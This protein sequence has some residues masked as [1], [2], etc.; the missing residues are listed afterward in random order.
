MP[1]QKWFYIILSSL[2]FIGLS[3]WFCLNEQY[4]FLAIP[5]LLILG[6]LTI[7]SL[8]ATFWVALFFTPL[9]VGLLEFFPNLG[10]DLDLPAEPLYIVITLLLCWQML[11]NQHNFKTLLRHPI[12]AMLFILL[13]WQFISSITSTMPAVS[14]KALFARIWI[15]LPSFV[16]GF[17]I[18][19]SYKARKKFFWLYILG[20]TAVI[21]YTNIRL[22]FYGLNNQLASNWVVEP[23]FPDHTSY[24]AMLVFFLFP[25]I[26][27][28]KNSTQPIEKMGGY[29]LIGIFLFAIVLSYTR[30]AWLSLAAA[31]GVFLIFYFRISWKI[32]TLSALAIA[33]FLAVAIPTIQNK[34]EDNS[35]ES[36]GDFMEHVQSM[37]NVT[38]D[39]SNLERINRWKCALR[40]FH[41]KP[42]VGWGPGTYKFQ[43]A[44][45]QFSYDRTIIST[46]FGDLGNA[47]SEYLGP[48]AEQGLPGFVI[49]ILWV[50][51][52][53]YFAVRSYHKLPTGK[54]KDLLLAII[55]SLASYYL[56]GILNN[57]LDT[58]KASVPVFA[59]TAMLIRYHIIV[60]NETY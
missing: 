49:R 6:L 53:F 47:H 33:V 21:V 44:P 3:A 32:L 22:S 52:T 34:L 55:L 18:F 45:F 13:L 29:F 20:L 25:L 40:M 12:A 17:L 15:V 30:A 48:L 16:L 19:S 24:G 26:A 41:E 2:A 5:L 59:T 43:Y 28:V 54:E 23:F 37:A 31:L 35:A 51:F 50:V 1:T 7:T 38:S 11:R 46:N 42:I 8:K 9:S 36:S 39:A 56:H 58:V 4:V 14:F 10:L 60:S 57:F 27:M